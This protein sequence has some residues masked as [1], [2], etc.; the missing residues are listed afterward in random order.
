MGSPGV[1]TLFVENLPE[2][3][4]PKGLYTLFTKFGVVKDVFIPF[5]RK[6]ATRSRFGFVRY[7]CPVAAQVA[8]RKA[9][10]NSIFGR[11][12]KGEI[13]NLA[14][15]VIQVK[16]NAGEQT[17]RR[18]SFAEVVRRGKPQ[19]GIEDVVI[20]EEY[21]NGWL[22]QSAIVI[23]RKHCQFS[24]FRNEFSKRGLKNEAL[25]CRRQVL[26]EWIDEWCETIVEW[27]KGMVTEQEREV[28]LRCY[29]VPFN[30][31]NNTNFRKIEELWGEVLE[32]DENTISM[33]TLAR[34]K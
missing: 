30:L 16:G 20:T 23:C 34:V 3:M 26:G 27:R 18:P 9:N 29:G 12:Q 10:G 24:D 13:Q 31:W 17:S 14:K 15:K 33:P 6:K 8:I 4:N 7:D 32:V 21:G 1:Q 5:K 19:G 22:H 11:E 28:W 2:S 25:K